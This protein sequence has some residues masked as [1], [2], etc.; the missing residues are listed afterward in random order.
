MAPKFWMASSRLTMT[1]RRDRST[2]PLA[3]VEVTII[4]SISGVRP[5]ATDMANRKASV[6]SLD[7]DLPAGQ[8]HGS[9]GQSGGDDHRQHFRSQAD[10]DGHGE[11]EGLRPVAFGE[12]VDEQRSEEH[13]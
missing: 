12:A 3:R 7:D 11:Q 5:T 6:Q 8:E 2:A 1:F 10:G 4:G 9:L 13:T